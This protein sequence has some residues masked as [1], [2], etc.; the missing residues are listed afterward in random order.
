MDPIV[1]MRSYA[2]SLLCKCHNYTTYT[3]QNSLLHIY[4]IWYSLLLL[5]YKTV[6][7]ITILN[8]VRNYKTMVSITIYYNF[9][10]PPFY[11]RSVLEQNVVLR[12]M[13]VRYTV[14][15]TWHTVCCAL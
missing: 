2:I 7:Y 6:Q 5:V 13:T 4:A 8:I 3:R 12:R 10:G 15:R 14:N 11:M 9:M 1:V